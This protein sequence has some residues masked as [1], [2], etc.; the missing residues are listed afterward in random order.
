MGKEVGATELDIGAWTDGSSFSSPMK[1][2]VRSIEM[3]APVPPAPMCPKTTRIQSTWHV[4]ALEDKVLLESI[5]MSLDVPCG[6][7]FN[8]IACDTFTVENGRLKMT[9]TCG[10]EWVQSS[11]MKSMVE[12]NVPP[13]LALMG[14]RVAKVVQEWWK[15]TCEASKGPEK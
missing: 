10:V 11:W 15:T 13:Q 1:G 4:V 6:T 3:R 5:T 2:W 14:A 8:A 12:L 9:R 7:N